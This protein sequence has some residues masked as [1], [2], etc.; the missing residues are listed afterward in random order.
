[1]ITFQQLFPATKVSLVL[2]YTCLPILAY[3]FISALLH[4]Y[5]NFPAFAKWEQTKTH[6]TLCLSLLFLII[7][8]LLVMVVLLFIDPALADYHPF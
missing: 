1:M 7:P 6:K 5:G 4:A 2:F 8:T 3:I